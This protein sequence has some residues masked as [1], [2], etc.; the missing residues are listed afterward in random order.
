M[1]D[2]PTKIAKQKPRAGLEIPVSGI[3]IWMA[4][5]G[6]ASNPDNCDAEDIETTQA[7]LTTG[8]PHVDAPEKKQTRPL[9]AP[10][11][12]SETDGVY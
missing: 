9:C 2:W 8:I 7:A 12:S 1:I 6:Q 10:G 11:A 5:D 3:G 4:G